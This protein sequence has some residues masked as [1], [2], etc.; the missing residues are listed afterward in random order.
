MSITQIN[1]TVQKLLYYSIA[2]IFIFCAT[3]KDN[4][5]AEVAETITESFSKNDEPPLN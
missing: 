2:F 3:G 5:P 4:N 1:N